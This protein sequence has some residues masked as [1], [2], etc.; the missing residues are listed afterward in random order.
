MRRLLIGTFLLIL[1]SSSFG[2]I[3]FGP[4]EIGSGVAF[5]DTF[6]MYC[7]CTAY[8]V[9]IQNGMGESRADGFKVGLN[10]TTVIELDGSWTTYT[11]QIELRET[12]PNEISVNVMGEEG[13]KIA[14]QVYE[15]D[16][17]PEPVPT[18]IY[19]KRTDDEELFSESFLLNHWADRFYLDITNGNPDGS[20]RIISGRVIVDGVTVVDEKE[21]NDSVFK[22]RKEIEFADVSNLNRVLIIT[23]GEDGD[24][25]SI[26]IEEAAQT[27]SVEEVAR[28]DLEYPRDSGSGIFMVDGHPK[29]RVSEEIKFVEIDEYGNTTTLLSRNI[30][31]DE[32]IEAMSPRCGHVLTGEG[33]PDN[34]IYR[35][36]DPQWSLIST[37][38]NQDLLIGAISEAGNVMMGWDMA[39]LDYEA[40]EG[41]LVAFYDKNGQTIGGMP[42]GYEPIDYDRENQISPDE[43]YSFTHCNDMLQVYGIDGQ[44]KWESPWKQSRSV[45]NNGLAVQADWESLLFHNEN[46]TVER[47][48]INPRPPVESGGPFTRSASDGEYAEHSGDALIVAKRSGPQ[49]CWYF[50]PSPDGYVCWQSMSDDGRWAISINPGVEFREA[51]LVGAGG[52]IIWQKADEWVCGPT[53]RMI[54]SDGEYFFLFTSD[55]EYELCNR[56]HIYRIAVE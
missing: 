13:A 36:Y 19:M 26:G 31:T 42:L 28:V 14:V 2:E 50:D 10:D 54:S 16:V 39:T 22:I 55:G 56:C 21:L 24:F 9:E 25:V 43:Q 47:R 23:S 6:G 30:E 8:F 3:L 49:S 37:I 15:R 51:S 35:L 7:R 53:R 38:T 17:T 33:L 48:V 34:R 40:C 45:V 29:V 4:V 18:R 5:Q 52:E 27:V 41:L 44:L 46:G 11:E 1:I 32:W 12:E 20:N